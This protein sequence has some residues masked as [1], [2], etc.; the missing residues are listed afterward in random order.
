MIEKRVKRT[1]DGTHAIWGW[2]DK[3]LSLENKQ[4]AIVLNRREHE[5]VKN[6]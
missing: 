1:G 4:N 3:D 2:G 5:E 6:K